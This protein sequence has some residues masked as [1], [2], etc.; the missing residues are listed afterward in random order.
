M[1]LAFT[2]KAEQLVVTNLI[3]VFEKGLTPGFFASLIPPHV[4][5]RKQITI[6]CL[7][8]LN[9]RAWAE[10]LENNGSGLKYASTAHPTSVCQGQPR[11]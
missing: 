11:D 3:S 1:I 7:N 5:H 2:L 6:Q 8:L 9:A 4:K 10:T